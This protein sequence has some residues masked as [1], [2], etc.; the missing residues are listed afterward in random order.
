[1]RS[2]ISASIAL[3]LC[4]VT[5]IVEAGTLAGVTLPDSAQVGGQ[6]LV[7]NGMGLREKYF[8][9]VY[10]GG[11]YLPKK[12]RNGDEA[13][14]ADVPKRITMQMLRTLEKATLVETMKESV[15][16]SPDG[17]E[18]MKHIDTFTSWLEDMEAG[19]QIIL[20]YVPNQGTT[21][22]VKGKAKGT[23]P[24][25]AFMRAIWGIY[26]GPVPPTEDLKRGL[27]GG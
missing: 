2:S 14:K 25:A 4:L 26:L 9:D 24:G 27:L 8:I 5:G 18:A 15:K 20:E 3:A 22:K 21:M 16:K 23:I 7:L 1:M 13:I 11:L 19:Q 12:T 17:A 10:V 6:N